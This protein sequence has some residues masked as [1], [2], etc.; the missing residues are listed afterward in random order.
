MNNLPVVTVL[1][2]AFIDGIAGILDCEPIG[3]CELCV[4]E[5]ADEAYC[6]S[7][8]RKKLHFCTDKD[9]GVKKEIYLACQ[10]TNTE[11]LLIVV[12]FFLFVCALAVYGYSFI[13]ARKKLSMT[14]FESRKLQDK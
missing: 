2:V 14:A 1:L 10:R 8:G 3:F 7:A 12:L 5:D 6:Q 11:D 4:A 9:A 13:Q